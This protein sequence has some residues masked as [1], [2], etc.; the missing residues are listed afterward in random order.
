MLYRTSNC[1]YCACMKLHFFQFFN[2]FILYPIYR[3]KNYTLTAITIQLFF[4]IYTIYCKK[5]LRICHK[6]LHNLTI[7]LHK[8]PFAHEQ[9][10]AAAALYQTAGLQKCKLHQGLP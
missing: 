9:R 1:T 6:K 2:F 3:K 5:K 10:G 7:F 4:V 8:L